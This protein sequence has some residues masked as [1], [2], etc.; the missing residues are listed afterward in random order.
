MDRTVCEHWNIPLTCEECLEMKQKEGRWYEIVDE[1]AYV[2]SEPYKD[3]SPDVS[4]VKVTD[5]QF[6]RNN[7]KLEKIWGET[8][9]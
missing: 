2:Y 1:W 6:Y 4:I 5:L 7:F 9:K 3:N 8:Y